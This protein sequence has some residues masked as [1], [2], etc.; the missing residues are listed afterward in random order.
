MQKYHF[1][2]SIGTTDFDGIIRSNEIHLDSFYTSINLL[3]KFVS[4]LSSKVKSGFEHCRIS[5]SSENFEGDHTNDNYASLCQIC[6]MDYWTLREPLD[7]CDVSKIK[8]CHVAMILALVQL[9]V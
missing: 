3:H 7:H 6:G 2:S 4:G 5:N 1:F 9:P 8:L